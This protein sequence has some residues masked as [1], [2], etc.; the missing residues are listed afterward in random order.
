MKLLR[1]PRK[2]FYSVL[3][4]IFNYAMNSP[5]IFLPNFTG[6]FYRTTSTR[7]AK[8]AFDEAFISR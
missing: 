4:I 1:K 7:L 3:F 2:T 5:T 6:F 8:R